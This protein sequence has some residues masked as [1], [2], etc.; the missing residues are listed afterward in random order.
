MDK[1][2]L[3]EK[4]MGTDRSHSQFQKLTAQPIAAT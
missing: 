1:K 3:T 2:K 4:R